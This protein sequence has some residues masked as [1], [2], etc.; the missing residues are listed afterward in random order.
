MITKILKNLDKGGEIFSRESVGQK[1]KTR[2]LNLRNFAPPLEPNLART[3]P[4]PTRAKSNLSHRV[5]PDLRSLLKQRAKLA[6]DVFFKK[7]GFRY[8]FARSML[9]KP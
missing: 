6:H 5:D 7:F 2:R 9:P 4:A 8:A 1:R 3:D